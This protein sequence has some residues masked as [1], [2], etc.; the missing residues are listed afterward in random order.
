M[1]TLVVTLSL[2]TLLLG[3]EASEPVEPAPAPSF[4]EHVERLIPPL[5]ESTGVAGTAVGLVERGRV[6]WLGG[7]GAADR[8]RG[9]PV[10]SSTVFNVGSI[11]K[12]V[13]AMGIMRLVEEGRLTLDRAVSEQSSRWSAPPGGDEITPRMLLSHTA[14][15]SLSAVPELD[16]LGPLPGLASE[17]ASQ[18]ELIGAPGD[19]FSYSGGGYMLLQLLLEERVGPFADYMAT[20]LFAPL[21]LTSTSYRWPA[22]LL[23]DAA[24]PYDEGVEVPRY[25]YVGQAAASLNSSVRDLA[26]LLAATLGAS[27]PVSRTSLEAM[28]APATHSE[29]RY[30]LRYG[31]GFDLWPLGEGDWLAGHAGQNTG[32]AAAFWSR[33]STGD[34]LVV[35]TNDSEGRSLWKWVHCDWV[36]WLS[37]VSWGGYCSGRP[38]GLPAPLEVREPA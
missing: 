5:L 17:V 7:F 32:W 6:T 28:R 15:L 13:A 27:T 34:G 12:P 14:G 30:G 9:L 22:A 11:S 36:Y 29:Q 8:E 3:A 1:H 35:L 20:E 38:D 2:A 16:P 19:A 25:R 10:R 24:T 4:A 37:G 21:G 23:A 18:V 33:P 26:H 31:L